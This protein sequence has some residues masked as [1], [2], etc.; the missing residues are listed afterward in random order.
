MKKNVLLMLSM[1]L[2]LVTACTDSKDEPVYKTLSK[3]QIDTANVPVPTEVDLTITGNIATKNSDEALLMDVATIEQL[4]MVEY[5]LSNGDDPYNENQTVVYQGVLMSDLLDF[6]GVRQDGSL[7]VTASDDYQAE[8]PFS[9]IRDY[10]L[11]LATQQNGEFISIDNLGPLRI[12]FPYSHYEEFGEFSKRQALT[13]WVW[14]IES[15]EVK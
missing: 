14:W 10:P 4:G 6:L 5:T 8:I 2:I 3:K 7:L 12:I 9:L 11:I 15:I 13:F 1:L